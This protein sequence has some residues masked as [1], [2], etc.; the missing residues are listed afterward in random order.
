MRTGGLVLTSKTHAHLSLCNGN[1]TSKAIM[2]IQLVVSC[3]QSQVTCCLCCL[4]SGNDIAQMG[5]SGIQPDRQ[6]VSGGVAVKY[7]GEVCDDQ[8]EC[9]LSLFR[10]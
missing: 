2:G 9:A 5:R 1:E 8:A 3:S 6:S 4:H 10:C 7:Q